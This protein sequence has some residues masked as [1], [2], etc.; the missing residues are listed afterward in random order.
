M[1][2]KQ[3][4]DLAFLTAFFGRS[5]LLVVPSARTFPPMPQCY[6]SGVLM[7]SV[8]SFATSASAGQ[9]SA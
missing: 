7:P 5:P 9:F 2:S 1:L 4:L 6:A 8:M 3:A